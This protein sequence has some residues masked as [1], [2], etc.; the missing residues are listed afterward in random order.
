MENPFWEISGSRARFCR[1]CNSE[2]YLDCAATNCHKYIGRVPKD[3]TWGS[4]L[5]DDY[6]WGEEAQFSLPDLS[7]VLIG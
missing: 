5:S 6:G 7:C 4:Q 3:P 1:V 2:G